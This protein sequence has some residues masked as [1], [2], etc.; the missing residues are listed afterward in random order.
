MS[1][2]SI[3][4]CSFVVNNSSCSSYIVF[5]LC[6]LERVTRHT[7]REQRI[8]H[9]VSPCLPVFDCLNVR[10]SV[11]LSVCLPVFS[12]SVCVCVCDYYAQ[13]L[14]VCLFLIACMCVCLSVC[15]SSCL[16]FNVCVCVC[17]C[18][19]ARARECVYVS[20]CILLSSVYMCSCSCDCVCV[21][22]RAFT[23]VGSHAA[24]NLKRSDLIASLIPVYCHCTLHGHCHV[25]LGT[26]TPGVCQHFV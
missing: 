5:F 21:S 1:D 13:C 26:Y 6:L 18:V 2:Y 22:V 8:Q 20:P 16:C 25:S 15:L 12:L 17:V 7:L 23:G 11:C 19:L 24:G 3:L 10:V 14:P 9:S 4:V